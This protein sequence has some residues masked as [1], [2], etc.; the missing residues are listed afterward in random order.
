MGADQS[1]VLRAMILYSGE[2]TSALDPELI[3][4]ALAVMNYPV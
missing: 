4:E 2:A 3:G 1:R